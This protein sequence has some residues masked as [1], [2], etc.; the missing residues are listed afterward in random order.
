VI[1][2]VVAAAGVVALFVFPVTHHESNEFTIRTVEGHTGPVNH[3]L[4]LDH[5]GSYSFGWS[6]SPA[7]DVTFDV[8]GPGGAHL[9]HG[10]NYLAAGT[11]SVTEGTVYTFSVTYNLA[12]NVTVNGI[13]SWSAP[14]L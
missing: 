4:S 10:Y 7:V 12:D 6:T 3:T 11:I 13:L 14:S 5:S 2:V 8:Y 1:A 9:Y